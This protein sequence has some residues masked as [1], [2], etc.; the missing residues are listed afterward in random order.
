MFVASNGLCLWWSGQYSHLALQEKITQEE[1]ESERD[2]RNKRSFTKT[3]VLL[4]KVICAKKPI[5]LLHELIFCTF[6]SFS[7][8]YSCTINKKKPTIQLNQMQVSAR[9]IGKGFLYT[10]TL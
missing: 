7:C 9:T 6:F 8:F 3:A 5:S 10:T 2:T 4:T 1:G